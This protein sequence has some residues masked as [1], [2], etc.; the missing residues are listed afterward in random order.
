MPA[1]KPFDTAAFSKKLG[2]S[3]MSFAPEEKLIEQQ[4]KAKAKVEKSEEE[5]TYEQTKQRK[6]RAVESGLRAHLQ[7]S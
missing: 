2:V 4:A 5:K 6:I 1:N 7:P 3:H